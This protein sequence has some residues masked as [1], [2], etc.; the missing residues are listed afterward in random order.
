M[1]VV[2]VLLG[3]LTVLGVPQQGPAWAMIAVFGVMWVLYLSIHSVGQVFYGYGWESMLLECGALVGLL[4]SHAVAPPLLMILFLR[5]MLLRPEF[6]AGM[7][8]MHGDASWRGL[9]AMAHHHQTQP[10]PGPLSRLAHLAPRWW[11]RLEVLGS[12]AVQLGIIWLVLLP[13]ALPSSAGGA[14]L[15]ARRC[16]WLTGNFP[17]L[18]WLTILVVCSAISDSCL[19]WAGGG[20]WPGCGWERWPVVGEPTP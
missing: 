5:W 8:K 10:M 17:R 13:H 1:C 16:L 4:G 19:R 11:H 3:V 2:G 7:I 12:H 18:S 15:L 20:P 9:T 6:G 14:V